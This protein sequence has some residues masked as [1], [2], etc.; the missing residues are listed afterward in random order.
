M[1]I[2]LTILKILGII[3]LI[4]L[5]I[6][7]TLMCLVLFVP[8]R[9]RVYFKMEEK[10]YA[11][12]KIS[13]LLHA[14]TAAFRYEAGEKFGKIKLFGITLKNFFPTEAQQKKQEEKAKRKEEKLK[15][16]EEKAKRSLEKKVKKKKPAKSVAKKK[17]KPQA[18]GNT[19]TTKT[20]AKKAVQNVKAND[21]SRQVTQT[22]QEPQLPQASQTEEVPVKESFITKLINKCKAFFEKL[23]TFVKKIIDK[24]KNIKYTI[25]SFWN[26]L[27]HMKETIL[28]YYEV[29]EREES[30]RALSKVKTQVVRLLKHIAPRKLKGCLEFGFD[31]PALTG[32]IFG[33]LCMFYALYGNNVVVVPNFEQSMVKAEFALSGKIRVVTLLHIGWKVLFDKDIRN[34]Y[35]IVTGGMKNE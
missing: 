34:L 5:G 26:K 19:Q 17:A 25:C 3:L 13:Y 28:W 4:L 18:T 6:F 9:Y 35:E 22:P 8:V 7:L 27:V 11:K 15:R 10:I 21:V 14:I 23:K 31:D 16:K 12:V 20:P 1:G 24:V 32:D 33:K 29:F 30:H 2:V